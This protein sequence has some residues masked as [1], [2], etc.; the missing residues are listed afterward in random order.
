MEDRQGQPETAMIH[1]NTPAWRRATLALCLGSMLVFI[2]LYA[3]QPLLPLLRDTHEA[4]TLKV[5]L[6]MS[7][8]TLT[9]D[10]GFNCCVIP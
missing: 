3:P 10:A 6:V 4:S 9:L 2:N 5:G 1:A 8:A 7:L